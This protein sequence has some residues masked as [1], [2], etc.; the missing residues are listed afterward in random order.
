MDAL[1]SVVTFNAALPPGASRST[2]R[3]SGCTT[4]VRPHSVRSQKC[5]GSQAPPLADTSAKFWNF[6]REAKARKR[7]DPLQ[8]DLPLRIFRLNPRTTMCPP[9]PGA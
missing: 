1:P 3:V 4:I 9:K 5:G 2:T 6:M 8:I 7:N